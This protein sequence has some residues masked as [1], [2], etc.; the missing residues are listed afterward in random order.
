MGLVPRYRLPRPTV[1]RDKVGEGALLSPRYMIRRLV[2]GCLKAPQ[3]YRLDPISVQVVISLRLL[4]QL[5]RGMVIMDK[6][7][8]VTL[9]TLRRIMPLYPRRP[10]HTHPKVIISLQIEPAAR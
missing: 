1:T 3:G 10:V 4:Y 2:T 6:D 5:R 7:G 8:A 9:R